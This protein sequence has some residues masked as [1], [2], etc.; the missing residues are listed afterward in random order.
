MDFPALLSKTS[1]TLF[2]LQLFSKRKC[3]YLSNFC[4]YL[5]AHQL[6]LSKQTVHR[7]ITN[8]GTKGL[9]L[10]LR[11]ELHKN[12]RKPCHHFLIGTSVPQVSDK[13]RGFQAFF[14]NIR[15]FNSLQKSHQNSFRLELK[16]KA[17]FN[18]G[19]LVWQ[20]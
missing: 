14:Q 6:S 2:S 4:C 18:G 16:C 11:R 9:V 19:T 17:Q 3:S 7:D 8:I 10:L 12:R 5:A 15:I 1:F 13:K 20:C